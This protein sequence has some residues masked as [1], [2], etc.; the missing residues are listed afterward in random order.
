MTAEMSYALRPL[1]SSD[2]I[3]AIDFSLNKFALLI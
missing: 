3:F 1:Q 2:W